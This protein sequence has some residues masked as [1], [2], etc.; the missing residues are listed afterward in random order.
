MSFKITGGQFRG[1]SMKTVRHHGF[2]VSTA[3]TREALF[4]ILAKAVPGASF[5]DLFAGCGSVGL[6]AVSRDAAAVTWVER[7]GRLVHCIRH[8]ISLLAAD[9][10][11]KVKV[12]RGDVRS[13][14]KRF[15]AQGD[16]FDIV[17]ADPPYGQNIALSLV[18]SAPLDR[19]IGD[20]GIVV[21]EHEAGETLPRACGRLQV[22]KVRKFGKS[23]LSF[24][25]FSEYNT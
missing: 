6:E 24:Y 9:G 17:F 15:V 1:R 16:R 4:S 18:D 23:T 11:C 5:L 12:N 20:T 22:V 10:V 13:T 14:V 2:R 21:L 7:A 19:L 25:G 3:T 8:N